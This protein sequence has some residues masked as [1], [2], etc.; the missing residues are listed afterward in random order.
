M[1]YGEGACGEIYTDLCAKN[2]IGVVKNHHRSIQKNDTGV[3][4]NI[5]TN[6]ENTTKITTEISNKDYPI[7][8]YPKAEQE[9]KKQIDYELIVSDSPAMKELLDGMVNIAADI[10][11]SDSKT[12]RVNK[13]NMPSE[14]VREKIKT[15]NMEHIKYIFNG[16]DDSKT[17]VKNVRA[18]MITMMYNAPDTMD[19]YYG[20]K[21][22]NIGDS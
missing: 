17:A 5:Q 7:I 2:D 8:S 22:R 4:E 1:T 16:L 19:L 11:S 21:A 13:E 20:A 10:L 6:T 3:S 12:I 18:V 15:L 9:F 14:R